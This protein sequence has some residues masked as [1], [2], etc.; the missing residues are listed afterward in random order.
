M[1][2]THH[3][4][5]ADRLG[6]WVFAVAALLGGLSGCSLIIDSNQYVERGDAGAR[7]MGGADMSATDMGDTD[8]GVVDQGTDQ[9]PV[10]CNGL[11]CQVGQ[12]CLNDQL[13]ADCRSNS[14]CA[15]GVCDQLV[16][17]CV[18][19][20]GS[21][22]DCGPG[23]TCVDHPMSGKACIKCDRDGDS[24]VSSW[25]LCNSVAAGRPRDCDDGDAQRFPG[26]VPMC[27]DGFL[28][29]CPT[30]QFDNLVSVIGGAIVE[31]GQ[32]PVFRV[33]ENVPARPQLSTVARAGDY[34]ARPNDDPN[35]ARWVFGFITGGEAELHAIQYRGWNSDLE[36][37]LFD[38][39]GGPLIAGAGWP[40]EA[41]KTEAFTVDTFAGSFR[42]GVAGQVAGERR[43]VLMQQS[44]SGFTVSSN[45]VAEAGFLAPLAIIGGTQA[46]LVYRVDR[47]VAIGNQRRLVAQVSGQHTS[48]TTVLPD[49]ND[50]LLDAEGDYVFYTPN[51]RLTGEVWNGIA[52]AAAN[53]GGPVASLMSGPAR[54]SRDR[55]TGLVT[56]ILPYV[57]GVRVVRYACTGAG[58]DNCASTATSVQSILP[59]LTTF[60]FEVHNGVIYLV[61]AMGNRV[62]ADVLTLDGSLLLTRR[63][64][65]AITLI[66]GASAGQTLSSI[67][68]VETDIDVG[69]NHVEIVVGAA[70][71]SDTAGVLILGTSVRA[72]TAL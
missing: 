26:A 62:V 32:L 48:A 47:A 10:E 38:Q 35:A 58:L 19:P 49:A 44:G 22:G 63:T 20:V 66:D 28:Q 33:A 41:G 64:P 1:R 61:T 52:N 60:D 21:C 43:A 18:D 27:A 46:D 16:G 53:T 6:R 24:F 30:P 57:D 23:F 54:F 2:T 34:L 11:T 3:L 40:I 50:F 31:L 29:G 70:A 59:G 13:C 65:S 39:Q 14:D 68:S 42:F 17:S 69:T 25:N 15:N 45:V 7:D 72:C 71:E 5:A 9:G 36:M 4:L 55:A 12:F 8:T 51:G 56:G 37:H 67:V